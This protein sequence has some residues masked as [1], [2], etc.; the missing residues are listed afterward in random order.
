[1]GSPFDPGRDG[2]V[3]SGFGF[4]T[5][6]DIPDE[7]VSDLEHGFGQRTGHLSEQDY[8]DSENKP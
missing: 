2:N 8:R 1:M 6:S 4:G 3:G 5:Q 7:H